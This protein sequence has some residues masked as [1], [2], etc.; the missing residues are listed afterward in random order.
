M[1]PIENRRYIDID[2]Q[3]YKVPWRN[4]RVVSGVCGS[5]TPIQEYSTGTEIRDLKYY[6][7]DGVKV[8]TF[9]SINES[10]KGTDG[11]S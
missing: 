2:N 11:S 1:Y 7:K 6:M 10:Q 3:R 8:I 9:I 5:V 4:Q